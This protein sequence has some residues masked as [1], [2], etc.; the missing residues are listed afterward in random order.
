MLNCFLN[1]FGQLITSLSKFSV[2]NLIENKKKKSIT[3]NYG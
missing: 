2:N 1:K 3:Y